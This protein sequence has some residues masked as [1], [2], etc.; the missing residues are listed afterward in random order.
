MDPA[1]LHR[2]PPRRALAVRGCRAGV[3]TAACA[4]GA[5]HAEPERFEIDPV[6]TR[7]VVFVGHAGFSRAVATLSGT[8][9]ELLFDEDDPASASVRATLPLDRLDFGDAAWNEAVRSDVLEVDAGAQACFVSTRV[10]VLD[11]SHLRVHGMLQIAQ[12]EAP[13]VLDATVNALRR[14]PMPPFPRTVGIS[15]R[16][17]I[18]RRDFGIDAFPRTVG[19]EV[20]IL[21]EFEATRRRRPPDAQPSPQETP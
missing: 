1:R 19:H 7:V 6:H 15:A 13:V 5:A 17:T 2:P 18:D 11:G 8:Q 21:I 3:L 12:G 20:E 16:T 9:G 4:M 10:D 14:H